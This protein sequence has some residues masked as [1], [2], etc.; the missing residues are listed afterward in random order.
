MPHPLV[1]QLRFTRSEWLRGLKAVTA[2]EAARRFG[3]INPIAWMIGHLAWQEQ[4]Y[5]LERAQGVVP[6][7]EVKKFG[8]GKELPVPP[9]DEAWAWWRAV[10]KAADPYLDDL[11]GDAGHQAPPHDLSRLVPSRRVAGGATDARTHEA[12]GLRRRLR[13]ESVSTRSRRRDYSV[14]M[15]SAGHARGSTRWCHSL[16]FPSRSITTPTRCA[17]FCGS[18]L[19]P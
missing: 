19:A 18:A 1:T 10:T 7:P 2:E 11:G 16:I 8:Y 14:L 17:P 4:L 3:P 9:L 12:P 5:W 13:E 6:V 15:T